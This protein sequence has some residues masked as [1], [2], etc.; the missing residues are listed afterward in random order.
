MTSPGDSAAL[1]AMTARASAAAA[2]EGWN[3]ARAATDVK[4]LG[5]IVQTV[6]GNCTVEEATAR[7]ALALDF[8]CDPSRPQDVTKWMLVPWCDVPYTKT[9]AAAQSRPARSRS[10]NVSYAKLD[11]HQMAVSLPSRPPAPST[12]DA[13][14]N[15]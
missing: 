7:Y 15:S 2:A 5:A 3:L 8:A 12:S 1:T 13:G 14:P 6:V 11:R 4:A 9:P 10:F